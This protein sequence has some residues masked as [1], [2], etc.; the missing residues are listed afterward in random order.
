MSAASLPPRAALELA[1]SLQQQGRLDDA[2]ALYHGVLSLDPSNFD[3]LHLLGVVRYRKRDPGGAERCLRE[4][5]RVTPGSAQAW[6]N[7]GTVLRFDDRPAEAIEACDRAL[8][9]AASVDR[10]AILVNRGAARLGLADRDGA[11]RDFEAALALDATHAGARAA[12]GMVRLSQGDFASGWAL[13]EA[14][15][16]LP[17]AAGVAPPTG[18]ASWNGRDSLAGRTILVQAEQGAGDAFQ[19]ARFLPRLEAL[20]A[21]VCVAVTP[22]LR[23]LFEASFPAARVVTS[24]DVADA[25][26]HLP[27]M[28]LGHRFAVDSASLA[29]AI[30]Y[31]RVPDDRAAAWR[32]D[33]MDSG[34]RRRIGLAWSGNPLYPDDRRRSLPAGLAAALCSPREEWISLQVGASAAALPLA[35]DVSHRLRDYADTAAALASL[36][37]VVAVD[38]S[39]AHLAGALGR[40]LWVLLPHAAE[41][42]WQAHREDSPWYPTAH[43]YRQA[44]RG[45]WAGVVARVRAQ[46]DAA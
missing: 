28:S 33:R 19:F 23:A 34:A 3:A 22:D 30:P 46:L 9:T 10:P 29:P 18:L 36:D 20:G 38:T 2:E 8:E 5:L 11:A 26:C 32:Q 15:L 37:L 21:R 13:Y 25:D 35:R 16:A 1:L 6:S 42:R 40:P 43:L 12:L 44:E 27:M 7:L 14:R 45:D 31:L 39:V 17:E 24:R 4:A 41:W